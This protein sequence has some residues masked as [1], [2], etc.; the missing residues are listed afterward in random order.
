MTVD[1]EVSRILKEFHAAGKPQALCCIAP[2]LAANV[3][4]KVILF[5]ISQ[6]AH[7]CQR[8]VKIFLIHIFS[9]IACYRKNLFCKKARL[10]N[11]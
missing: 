10:N 1:P 8:N 11:K 6:V 3:L 2:I 4:G 7:L 9:I 5:L